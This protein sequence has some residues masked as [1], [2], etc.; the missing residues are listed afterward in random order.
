MYVC[1]CVCARFL[2]MCKGVKVA[3]VCVE[4]S[5][6]DWKLLTFTLSRKEDEPNQKPR[7]QD[8]F[9]QIS[10]LN[11]AK[12]FGS[13]SSDVTETDWRTFILVSLQDNTTHRYLDVVS[14]CFCRLWGA[15]SRWQGVVCFLTRPARLSRCNRAREVRCWTTGAGQ[16]E[17]R[18]NS[19]G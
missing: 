9:S 8:E 13:P 19:W 14:C 2:F 6:S 1:V 5:G 10:P 7:E 11:E 12:L 16:P 4:H 17:N 18:Y 3:N 15:V